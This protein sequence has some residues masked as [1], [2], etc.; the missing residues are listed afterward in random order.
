MPKI[1]GTPGKPVIHFWGRL[2]TA[3]E[4]ERRLRKHPLCRWICRT[5]E[6]SPNVSQVMP[7]GAVS[8]SGLST[9]DAAARRIAEHAA[10]QVALGADPA[11]IGFFIQNF[12]DF[13]GVTPEL[14]IALDDA[15]GGGREPRNVLYTEKSRLG[16]L[17]VEP[18]KVPNAVMS[19][20]YRDALKAELQ[21]RSIGA[22]G[23]WIGDSERLHEPW[24]WV[25]AASPFG[26]WDLMVADARY[27]TEV[28]ALGAHRVVPGS[29][30]TLSQLVAE[31]VARVP[32]FAPVHNA[33]TTSGA[34]LAFYP[35]MLR[36]RQD[37]A[38][39]QY[40][41]VTI[42]IWHQDSF[43]ED[44]TV[45][46]YQMQGQTNPLYP[47]QLPGSGSNNGDHVVGFFGLN[48]HAPVCYTQVLDGGSAADPAFAR[49]SPGMRLG[50]GRVYDEQQ[51]FNQAR[52]Q[53]S[54]C[55]YG[56]FGDLPICPWLRGI[57]FRDHAVSQNPA[58]IAV[59]LARITKLAATFPQVTEVVWWYDDTPA[60]GGDHDAMLD[61]V[62]QTY[63]EWTW[64]SSL[65]DWEGPP[66]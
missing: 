55:A 6:G 66:V 45:S 44:L 64:N 31:A 25:T 32:T 13:F 29:N 65:Q 61:A 40:A 3:T 1:A 18:T 42:D 22:L 53:I 30:A 54:A 37:A 17:T 57:D 26:T 46:N 62:E 63:P 24:Q 5:F 41:S 27:T 34:N 11:T 23:H 7:D 59:D 48:C 38:Q 19:A 12:A 14:C 58:P 28:I 4:A 15:V 52:R 60:V 20:L 9:A 16:P 49:F 51:M 35:E 43:W 39:S 56:G 36:L 47:M 10:V 8:I 33:N 2:T 21:A 50:P